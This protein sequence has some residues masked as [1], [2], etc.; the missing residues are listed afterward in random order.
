MK[1]QYSAL[2]AKLHK[3]CVAVAA[4]CLAIMI[5]II[6]WGVFT[7][8]VLGFGSSWPEPLAILL[9]IVFSF[10]AASACYRDGLHIAVMAVPD[11]V[12]P[13]VR[14]ILGYVAEASM[15]SINLFML[16]WGAELMNTTWH[17]Y[18][19]EFPILRVGLSYAP[20]PIGGAI[21]LLFVIERLWKGELFPTPDGATLGSTT[22]E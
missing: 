22:M 3:G 8:Y 15:V 17:Q 20:V 11:M 4:S 9:L 14:R 6:P 12:P 5:L 10:F 2:M 7:R 19:G 21:T 16:I 13:G 18:I 1:E